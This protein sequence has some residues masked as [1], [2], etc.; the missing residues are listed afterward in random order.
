MDN[1]VL[2]TD[3]IR[4]PD[5]FTAPSVQK[6]PSSGVRYKMT[7]S[8]VKGKLDNKESVRVTIVKKME[9]QRDFFSEPESIESDGLEEKVIFYRIERELLIEEAIKKANT[10][11]T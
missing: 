10:T 4:G 9:K 7:L 11:K 5:G 1:G 2:E 8:L 3:W 6:D